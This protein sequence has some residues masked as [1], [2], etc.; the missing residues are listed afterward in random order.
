[1]TNHFSVWTNGKRG[2]ISYFFAIGCNRRALYPWVELVSV[3]ETEDRAGILGHL[4]GPLTTPNLQDVRSPLAALKWFSQQETPP[5]SPAGP[6]IKS[7]PRFSKIRIQCLTNGCWQ[8]SLTNKKSCHL[9][10][11]EK[12]CVRRGLIFSRITHFTIRC[13]KR[14]VRPD[15]FRGEAIAD[16]SGPKH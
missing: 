12:D 11:N 15:R 8:K 7:G 4:W 9:R 1:M 3:Y 2:N 6:H 13:N 14:N 16:L 5:F 10:K